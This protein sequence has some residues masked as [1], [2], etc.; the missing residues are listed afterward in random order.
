MIINSLFSW[1]YWT[2]CFGAL[3]NYF[4]STVPSKS[5]S[6][7]HK[8]SLLSQTSVAVTILRTNQESTPTGR[9]PSLKLLPK[10]TNSDTSCYCQWP[11]QGPC[12]KMITGHVPCYRMTILAESCCA[13][14]RRAGVLQ[15]APPLPVLISV[16]ALDQ[17]GLVKLSSK[18]YISTSWF[19]L[20]SDL[21]NPPELLRFTVV[22]FLPIFPS[23][24]IFDF[25]H[26]C[27][28]AL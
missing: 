4:Y 26:Q 12:Y 9:L 28:P 3:I 10:K 7:Q 23:M 17:E 6:V 27:I 20:L 21:I 19:I 25:C 8:W 22:F 2:S 18:A 24:P 1:R 14:Q 15:D 11:S 5:S 13:L 16:V